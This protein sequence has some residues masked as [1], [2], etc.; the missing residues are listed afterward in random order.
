MYH[1]RLVDTEKMQKRKMVIYLILS[2]LKL[3]YF[4]GSVAINTTMDPKF[5]LLVAAFLISSHFPLTP[6]AF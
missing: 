6:F 2:T 5:Q 1:L 4:A 3:E